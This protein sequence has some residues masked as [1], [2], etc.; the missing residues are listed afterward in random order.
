MFGNPKYFLSVLGAPQ[1]PEKDL[2]ESGV[3]HPEP[4]YTLFLPELGDIMLLYCT[5][6]YDKHAMRIPGIGIVLGKN[7]LEIHYRY[8]PLS[9]AIPKYVIDEKFE[10]TDKKK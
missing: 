3:Y 7:S 5:G 8:L 9:N 4:K 6:S 10:T 2:V 1:P